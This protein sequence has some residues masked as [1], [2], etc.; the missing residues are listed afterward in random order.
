MSGANIAAYEELVNIVGLNVI[1][2]GG[3]TSL[4]DIKALAKIGV[5]GAII[6][7]ALYKNAIKLFEA[8]AL[9]DGNAH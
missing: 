5:Y 1:A 7:K 2:S 8:I 9:G 6:G 4:E 3:V